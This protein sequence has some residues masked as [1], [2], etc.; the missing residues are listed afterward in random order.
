MLSYRMKK[1]NPPVQTKTTKYA[2]FWRRYLAF[3]LDS[4]VIGLITSAFSFMFFRASTTGGLNFSYFPGALLAFAYHAFFW[5]QHDGQTVGKKLMGVKVVRQDGKPIDLTTAITRYIGYVISGAVLCLGY[6]SVAFN[7]QKL[8]WHDRLAKTYVVIVSK[9]KKIVTV[10]LSL[11]IG[12]PFLIFFGAIASTVFIAKKI[13]NSDFDKQKFEQV[14][15]K[16]GEF[17]DDLENY[18]EGSSSADLEDIQ[19]DFQESIEN[20]VTPA[21]L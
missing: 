3:F 10:I 18:Q 4:F 9:P 21:E 8:G 1:I 6:L 19:N 5:I 7:R 17:S 16:L 11:F 15:E 12:I 2:G 14:I 13:K 20:I